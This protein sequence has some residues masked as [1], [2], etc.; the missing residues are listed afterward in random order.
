MGEVVINTVAPAITDAIYNACGVR[1]RDLPTTP[2]KILL[3][4]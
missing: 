1:I 3:K 2:E 4:L